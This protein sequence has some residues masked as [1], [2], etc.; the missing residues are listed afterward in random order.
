MTAAIT[1]SSQPSPDDLPL[2]IVER[3]GI[4]HPDT[5]ADALA[6]RMSV[7]Y[8]RHCQQTF[9]AVLHHNL[10]KL[11]LRGGH[12]H[13]GPGV[14]EMIAPVTLMIGGRVSTSFG[15]QAIDHRG[16]F[17]D[18]AR[19]YLT[20]VLPNFDQARWLR[21]EHL[22]SDRSRYPIWFHPRDLA[23]LPELTCPTASDTVAVTAWW[24]H[25]P[26]E[27]L[28]L[29]LERHL[30]Q[31]ASGPADLRLGQDIKVMA[32]RHA[33]RVDV[34]VNV[35]VHPLA[36]PDADTYHAILRQVHA[37]LDRVAARELDGALEYQLT[38][39]SGDT[40]PYRGKKHYLLGSGSCLEFGEEG[41]VGRGNTPSGLIPIH[42]PKSV[43]AAFGKNPT[44][45]AGKV[46][47]VHAEQIAR[48][49]HAATGTPS[50]VTIMA[51]HSNPLREPAVTHVT[52]HGNT[53]HAAVTGIVRDTLA[54][55]DHLALAM[56]GMLI[57]R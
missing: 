44:Y 7:A 25:T 33:R 34:T 14:F 2:E 35:A 52:L 24:P 10:D 37:E 46:Y 42:R 11:Y 5:L 40:N 15:D 55:T 3:K 6:E 30:N 49:V 48:A 53:D 4:G 17:E 26:A 36:A 39:N 50:T 13:T 22:T 41:F 16:L 43:E 47:A 27:R 45:H 9:G 29:A 54:A 28:T 19:S 57:P 31:Q 21:I 51:Q 20:T 8:S 23:D 18:V 1:V 56:D 32:V 12:A 38:L